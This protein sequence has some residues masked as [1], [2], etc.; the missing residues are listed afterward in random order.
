MSFVVPGYLNEKI[1]EKK[2]RS[3][4]TYK[5]ICG[6]CRV[7]SHPHETDIRGIDART[8]IAAAPHSNKTAN[9]VRLAHHGLTVSVGHEVRSLFH[10]CH[11]ASA[12]ASSNAMI[13]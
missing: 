12:I 11:T 5:K 4:E 10:G 6:I 7:F 8:A 9:N 3:Q 1:E 2:S 13:P